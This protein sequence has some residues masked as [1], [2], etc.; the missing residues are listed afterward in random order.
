METN[1]IKLVDELVSD[2]PPLKRLGVLV[3]RTRLKSGKN[4]DV[5]VEDLKDDGFS[6]SML[7]SVE[8]GRLPLSWEQIDIL[9]DYFGVHPEAFRGALVG[10]HRAIWMEK[11]PGV[12]LAEQFEKVSKVPSEYDQA[13]L[14]S[15]LENAIST[16]GI[17]QGVM[18]KMARIVRHFSSF[19]RD[20]VMAA[21]V[22]LLLGSSQNFLLS[23]LE[24]PTVSIPED[25]D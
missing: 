22:S 1:E 15:A 6:K 20:A 23:V 17:A 19:Q 8:S 18:E 4:L 3:R 2:Y 5:V 12:R 13:E 21:E 9:C 16:M 11:K 7:S 25:G 24:N 10:W 14:V